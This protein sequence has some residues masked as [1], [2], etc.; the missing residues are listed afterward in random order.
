MHHALILTARIVTG[1]VASSWPFTLRSSFT[2][3]KRALGRTDWR[4]YGHRFMTGQKSQIAL[5]QPFLTK[6]ART[7]RRLFSKFFGHK[8]LSLRAVAVSTNLSLCGAIICFLLV[9]L[10]LPG[11]DDHIKVKNVALMILC[12]VGLLGFAMIPSYSR[13]RWAVFIACLPP[14]VCVFRHSRNGDLRRY[15]S[16]EGHFLPFDTGLLLMSVASDCLAIV[17]MRKLFGSITENIS[18]FRLLGMIHCGYALGVDH[19]RVSY[20]HILGGW[21]ILCGR[22]PQWNWLRF[23]FY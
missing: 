8:L 11:D 18:V 14:R 2:R 19:R 3:T 5:R 17:V 16:A 15:V 9:R 20:R 21:A 4:I 7:L 13:K 22:K 12:A 10:L 23:S 1:L 6:L